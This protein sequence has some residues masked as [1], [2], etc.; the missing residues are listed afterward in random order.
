M[1]AT[2]ALALISEL[3]GIVSLALP[4]AEAIAAPPIAPGTVVQVYPAPVPKSV[5]PTVGRIVYCYLTPAQQE[6]Y[7]ADVCFVSAEG[8]I[9][10]SGNTS[11]GHQF[12]E[13]GLSLFNSKEEVPEGT[14]KYCTWM[15]YQ[16][17]QQAKQSS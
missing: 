8:L 6:P 2:R 7:R 10:V 14:Q 1:D 3:H 12:I 13:L 5:V 4:V 15:P 11:I 17:Q 16:V 9:H